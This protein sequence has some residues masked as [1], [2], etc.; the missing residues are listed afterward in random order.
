MR[1]ELAALKTARDKKDLKA[2]KKA[3]KKKAARKS[4]NATRP[5]AE[6][7][8][9][10]QSGEFELPGEFEQIVKD[11]VESSEKEIAEHP[12][13]AVGLAFLLGVLAGRASKS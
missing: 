11:L 9:A 7:K 4:K 3:A 8:D 1:G 6:I 5:A 13:I 2:I 10:E 12:A